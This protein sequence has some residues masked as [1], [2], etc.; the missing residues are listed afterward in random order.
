MLLCCSTTPLGQSPP[1]AF[2]PREPAA[3]MQD[4]DEKIECLRKT[5]QGLLTSVKALD[6]LIGWCYIYKSCLYIDGCSTP[7]NILLLFSIFLNHCFPFLLIVSVLF[8]PDS[9]LPQQKTTS[10]EV[11]DYLEPRV[12]VAINHIVYHRTTQSHFIIHVLLSI[13]P[14]IRGHLSLVSFKHNSERFFMYV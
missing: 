3:E 5:V 12:Q 11:M 14:S 10:C 7:F 13:Y 6:S 2:S 8:A 1:N 4:R 9:L